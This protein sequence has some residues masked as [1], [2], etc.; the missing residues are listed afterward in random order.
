MPKLSLIKPQR[1]KGNK[2]FIYNNIPKS[3][4]LQD[5]WAWSTSDLMSNATRGVLAEFI[6]A[7]SLGQKKKVRSEWEAYDLVYKGIKIEIKS[8]AYIQSWFQKEYSK[9]QFDIRKTRAWDYDTNKISKE[10][11]RQAD[12]Y[13]FALLKH[14]DQKTINP[15][16]LNQWI[17]YILSRKKLDKIL[18][19]AKTI[20]L[21]KLEELN[22]KICSYPRIKRYILEET[23]E[24]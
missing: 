7:M 5:F 23:G 15:L 8:A 12:I 9:I 18:P 10:A 19:N 11:L 13:V 2:P 4:S 20:G 14:N 21:K 16:N 1:K 22:P 6:V 3:A 24:N 17:F